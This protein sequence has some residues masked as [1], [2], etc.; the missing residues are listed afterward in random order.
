MGK[1]FVIVKKIVFTVSAFFLISILPV[2]VTAYL[3]GDIDGDDQITLVEAVNALQV[4]S[5]QR[6]ALASKTINVPA[7]VGTIQGAVDAAAEGDKIIIAAG[8]YTENLSITKNYITLEGAGPDATIIQGGTLHA[9]TVQAVTGVSLEG[10]KVQEGKHGIYGVLGANFSIANVTV[11]DA[12]GNG[13]RVAGNSMAVIRDCA[14]YRS[15]EDGIKFFM[16]SS[17]ALRGSIISNNNA[18]AGID[19]MQNSS[20]LLDG[21]SEL[22]GG[23]AAIVTVSNN[24]GQGA[25]VRES[26]SLLSSGAQ[27]TA[28]GN[29]NYGVTV[30]GGSSVNLISAETWVV[31]NG[32]WR[33]MSV[34]GASHFNI[35]PASSLEVKNNNDRGIQVATSSCLTSNG[36]LVIDNNKNRGISLVLSS[37]LYSFGSLTVRN[38][39]GS[40]G[41]GIHMFQSELY[42]EGGSVSIQNNTGSA[43]HG[44]NAN[45]S[46][47]AIIDANPVQIKDNQGHGVG[48]FVNAD[49]MIGGDNIAIQNNGQSGVFADG[50]S[51]LNMWT[52]TVSGNTVNDVVLEFGSQGTFD[53]SN[54]DQNR[55]HCGPGVLVR[56]DRTCP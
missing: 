43:G 1:G 41:N 29:Q 37:S 4:V 16:N 5:G 19:V 50:A 11:E 54:F 20:V 55:I 27:L 18:W 40:P 14:V 44:I 52:A 2:S 26:S 48:L 47:I 36:T 46:K 9:I 31:E 13:I 22:A 3:K 30:D 42:L 35:R 23:I 56:G 28:G 38:T 25:R 7:E 10:F 12:A 39:T 24:T 17:G 45:K 6:E 8:T 34:S 51:V 21:A 33:G 53:N 15:G 32:G 49:G